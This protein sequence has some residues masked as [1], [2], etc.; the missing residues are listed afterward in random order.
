MSEFNG[1]TPSEDESRLNGEE[2]IKAEDGSEIEINDSERDRMIVRKILQRDDLNGEGVED[3]I[4]NELESRSYNGS[5]PGQGRKFGEYLA[6]LRY[7]CPDLINSPFIKKCA[8][9]MY[10]GFGPD[11]D[12]LELEDFGFSLSELAGVKDV[13]DVYVEPELLIDDDSEYLNRLKEK[14]E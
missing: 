10:Y 11:H 2:V 7:A 4:Y 13:G 6:L 9:N 3:L 1:Y 8:E 5:G 14:Y 12:E